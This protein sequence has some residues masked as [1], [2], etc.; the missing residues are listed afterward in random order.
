MYI[1]GQQVFPRHQMGKRME[2]YGYTRHQYYY[3]KHDHHIFAEGWSF[4][5][6][7][8]TSNGYF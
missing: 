4:V 5:S 2:C 8:P 3:G 7:T 1:V 6:D